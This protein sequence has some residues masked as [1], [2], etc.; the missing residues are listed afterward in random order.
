MCG[1]SSRATASASFWNRLSSSS[2][3]S[4][5]PDHLQR[6]ESI[7]TDLAGLVDDAHGAAAQLAANLVVAEVANPGAWIERAIIAG[8]T[9][10]GCEVG[11]GCRISRWTGLLRERRGWLCGRSRSM[12]RPLSPAAPQA[13]AAVDV[14][15]AVG[16]FDLVL[17]VQYSSEQAGRAQAL[18][19]VGRHLAAAVRT[20]L[21][22]GHL[23]AP[24][25]DRLRTPS[26]I[27]NL[28]KNLTRI[29]GSGRDRLKQ[30]PDLVF[31]LGRVVEGGGD[32][33]L[34]NLAIA[35]PK[36]VNGHIHGLLGL[37]ELRSQGCGRNGALSLG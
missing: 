11:G 35:F 15:L 13:C 26:L 19:G 17:T 25:R 6:H 33:L 37:A 5:R 16:R 12:R 4:A 31:H 8:R 27:R 7:E 22:F 34:E 1:W 28:A 9:I 2:P 20:L 21:R 30:R 3:A 29:L 14:E 24:Y 36:P 18:R 23:R 32:L 10:A